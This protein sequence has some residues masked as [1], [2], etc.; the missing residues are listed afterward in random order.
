MDQ[1]SDQALPVV[2]ATYILMATCVKIGAVNKKMHQK[3]R[4][5]NPSKRRELSWADQPMT[6]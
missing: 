6:G 4:K 2:L 3:Q 1:V 5:I